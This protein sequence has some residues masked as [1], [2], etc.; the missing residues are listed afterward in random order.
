MANRVKIDVV[1]QIRRQLTQ[2]M[3]KPSNV[4]VSYMQIYDSGRGC[5]ESKPSWHELLS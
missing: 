2:D 1:Q 5:R 3:R 4:L